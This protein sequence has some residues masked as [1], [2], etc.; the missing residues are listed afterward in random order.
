MSSATVAA[1]LVSGLGAAPTASA[2]PIDPALSTKVTRL[3]QD[4]R[5]QRATSAAV[6]VDATSGAEL[7]SRYAGRPTTPASNTKIL[8]AVAAM[9]VLGPSYRFKTDVIRR[10]P[11]VAG[12]LQGNLYL[13]GYGDP[14]TM[15]RDL[16]TLA[17]KVKAAGINRI[18]RQLVADASFFDSQRYNPTWSTSYASE[19]YAA[20]TAALTVA[21]NLDY[22]S[23]TVMVNYRPG[24]VGG[25][26]RISLTPAAAGRYVNI[27][28]LTVTGGTGSSDTFSVRRTPGTNTVTVSG[29]V[30][31]GRSVRSDWVT[32]NKPE[33]Y[34][35]AVFRAA[36]TRAGVTV[37]GGT[38][39][40]T[41]PAGSRT[42]IARDRSMTLS[43]L[44]VPFMKFSNNM[45]AEA[46][47]KAMA[48]TTGAQ[49]TWAAGLRLTRAYMGGLGAPMTG[50]VLNDGSGLT[51][52][53]KITPRAMGVVLHKVRREAWFPAFYASLPVA[54]VSDRNIGGTL[55]NRMRNTRAAGNAHA[56][57]GSLTGVTALSGYVRGVDGRLYAFSMLSQYSGSTPRPVEDLLVITLANHRR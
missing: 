7:Y 20:Q 11:V 30:P 31:A 46:L 39:I 48:T 5:V 6:V 2:A 28:N 13:K 15:Q 9:D 50:I 53:N 29:R 52:S 25:K 27:R 43:A 40:M 38:K 33:L 35:A 41:T 56:K 23:G 24:A 3:M 44:L 42:L 19:Y 18:S 51:R 16:R 49:G 14:T 57:T 34:A 36:L 8:T 54:G 1:L 37:A 26:A 4:S 17:D 21:P 10:G 55:Q 32:V 45:H 47:T 12:T 22:D